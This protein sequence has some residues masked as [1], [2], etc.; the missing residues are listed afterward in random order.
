MP[1]EESSTL[2]TK[3]KVTDYSKGIHFH[4]TKE[5]QKQNKNGVKMKMSYGPQ[6]TDACSW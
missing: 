4:H 2:H 5:S 6:L 3:Q 1:A